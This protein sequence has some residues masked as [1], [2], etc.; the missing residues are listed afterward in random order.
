MIRPINRDVL[1]LA[2]KA[3]PATA[4]DLAIAD[5]L[6]DT[7]R[8]HA[9]GCVGMA[10]NMIGQPVAIIAYDND[11]VYEEMFNPVLLKGTGVYH[12]E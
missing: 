7:L 12:T 4:D 3:R 1:L 6:L 10:A 8:A 11:G 5:D 2:Q 9:E